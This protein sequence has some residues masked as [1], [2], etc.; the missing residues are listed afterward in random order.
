[1]PGRPR[2]RIT[3]VGCLRAASVERRLAGRRE[4]DV[5]APGPEVRGERAED[6][7][8]VVDDEDP[9]HRAAS[10]RDDD[11][12]PAAGCV[13]ELDRAAHR[14]DEALARRRGRVRRLRRLESPSRW[15][16]RNIRSRSSAGTPGP[17]STIRTS[18][19][20]STAPASTRGGG[21]VG[22]NRPW[23][24]SMMLAS[25]RS[26]R[27]A[28]ALTRRHVSG[29]S[30]ADRGAA[31]AEAAERRRN[32]LVEAD[33]LRVELERA[34]LEPAHVEQIADQARSGGR[35]PRRSCR[36]TRAAPPAVQSTSS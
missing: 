11:G 24:S 13:L 33:R 36:G 26:S 15:N 4:V 10:S 31:W 6:L 17:R 35:S 21:R 34:G 5:V 29:T 18:T 32:D 2:S 8:L 3:S 22:E 25:A 9:G 14:L 12:E 7:R 20:P 1:M 30:S 19:P 28:S 27:P 16:G 23:R